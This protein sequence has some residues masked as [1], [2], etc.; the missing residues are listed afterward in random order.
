MYRKS[1]LTAFVL[2]AC[3]FV[4]PEPASSDMTCW[5]AGLARWTDGYNYC[6]TDG[7]NCEYCEVVVNKV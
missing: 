5:P 3:L 1:V 4:A 2:A 7:N 6:M